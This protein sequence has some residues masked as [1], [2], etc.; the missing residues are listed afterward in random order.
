MLISYWWIALRAVVMSLLLCERKLRRHCCCPL[1]RLREEVVARIND[2]R[3]C[4]MQ[5]ADYLLRFMKQQTDALMA[6][7][8][9]LQQYYEANQL[10]VQEGRR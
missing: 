2:L 7:D 3:C 9:K 6:K 1:P 8:E 10:L 4:K 5:K